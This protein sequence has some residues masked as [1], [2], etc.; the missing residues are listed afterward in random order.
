MYHYKYIKYKSKYLEL[1]SQINGGS[2]KFDCVNPTPNGFYLEQIL[3]GEMS[4]PYWT[5]KESPV[6]LVGKDGIVYKLWNDFGKLVID[7]PIA[8]RKYP[9]RIAICLATHGSCETENKTLGKIY[10]AKGDTCDSILKQINKILE[11]FHLVSVDDFHYM[12]ED[13]DIAYV[14]K[15]LFDQTDLFDAIEYNTIFFVYFR[16]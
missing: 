5:T 12:Q 11:D 14:N 1:K 9:V 4:I 6:Q 7:P 16:E 2:R 15:Q 3:S 10:V 8:N 13:A